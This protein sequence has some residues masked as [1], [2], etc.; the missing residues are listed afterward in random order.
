MTGR[1]ALLALLAWGGVARAQQGPRLELRDAG[2]GTGPRILANEINRPHDV[3]PPG[4]MR[5]LVPRTTTR[6][7]TL[8]VLGRDA[9]IE[10]VV[11]GDVIVVAGD[12][13]MH[14]GARI[15]GRAIAIGGGV[16]RSTLAEI[17]AGAESFRDFTYDIAPSD[18]GFALSYRAIEQPTPKPF[19]WA[20]AYGFAMPTY[21]RSNGASIG[22]GPTLAVP[23]SR[24]TIEPRITYRSQLGRVD[25]S[26]AVGD[27]IARRT[28]VHFAASH[29]TLS[30]DTWIRPD[31]VNSAEFLAVGDDARN[32]YRAT[33]GELAVQRRWDSVEGAVLAYVGA[34]GELAYTVRPGD[35]ATSAPWTFFD[36][37]GHDDAF[38]PNP[39]IDEG[40]IGS[41]IG[42]LEWDWTRAGLAVA[43]RLDEELGAF[44]PTCSACGLAPHQGF[45]QTTVNGRVSF[46]TFGMQA[47]QLEAHAVVS[48]G[49]ALPRQR[50]AYLGGP[51]TIP[52]LELLELGGDQL[53]YFDAR[54]T[55]PLSMVSLPF[56]GSPTLALREVIGGAGVG[57]IPA[58]RQ[59]IGPR[60]S[61][62]FLYGEYL[63]DP[64]HHFSKVE[65]GIAASR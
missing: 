28:T 7:R 8:I 64:V 32:Y 55:A 4:G 44:D 63:V 27:S 39:A 17:V 12:L 1:V 14:P 47:F 16:Y 18:G 30:N 38:R 20:G 29:T 46:P 62:G 48:S 45:S 26:I 40:D 65:F 49:G 11:R 37:G 53:L 23:A 36:R 5:Y 24:I 54:Y 57:R 42:G 51:G 50:W 10:G 59:A 9:V 61:L 13:Y 34:R 52:T 6:R 35:S 58:L 22:L 60:L 25:P 19:A 3:I 15:D 56:V 33:R 41:F 21:D 31:L 43:T 2:P